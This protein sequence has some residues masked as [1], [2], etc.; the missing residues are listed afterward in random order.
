MVRQVFVPDVE[1]YLR[2]S[3]FYRFKHELELPYDDTKE[4]RLLIA[5]AQHA[6]RSWFNSLGQGLDRKKARNKV[7]RILSHFWSKNGGEGS[8]FPLAHA[9]IINILIRLNTVFKQESDLVI[10]GGL[11]ISVAVDNTIFED[12]IDG[13]FIRNGIDEKAK[14]RDKTMIMVQA[15][16]C[17]PLAPQVV[18]MR[19]AM[20][21]YAINSAFKPNPYPLRLLTVS[22][23]DCT[24]SWYDIDKSA[25][26]EFIYLARS[27]V[28]HLDNQMY[29]PTIHRNLCK[30]CP[31]VKI[32]ST[33]FCEPTI[34]N[35]LV[36]KTRE[37]L[38]HLT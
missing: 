1:D 24:M 2:C 16:P 8:G 28:R 9:R 12:T 11:P 34:S 33:R 3:L 25:Y 15:I 13:V 10:G 14:L 37:N 18:K 19:K 6:I 5:S 35:S 21:R 22:L 30:I 32:C 36:E 29:L 31:Y 38:L 7:G 4:D 20:T 17:T 23:P 26:N 27:V